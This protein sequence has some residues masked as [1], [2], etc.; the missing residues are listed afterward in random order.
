MTWHPFVAGQ[1]VPPARVGGGPL[2]R[3]FA[4]PPSCHR[5]TKHRAS[6]STSHPRLVRRAHVIGQGISTLAE[7]LDTA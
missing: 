3:P 6:W 5:A 7:I 4:P 1:V 2:L